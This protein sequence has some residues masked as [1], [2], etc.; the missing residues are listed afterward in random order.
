MTHDPA[1]YD[2]RGRCRICGGSGW[3]REFIE[4]YGVVKVPCE[5]EQGKQRE[6]E[7]ERKALLPLS[8]GVSYWA[9]PS[10][11]WG[12]SPSIISG[13]VPTLD[14]AEL[15]APAFHRA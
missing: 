10:V 11:T 6:R 4:G 3:T 5:C 8:A 2:K 1:L 9:V 12:S 14:L 7:L 15:P 13:H